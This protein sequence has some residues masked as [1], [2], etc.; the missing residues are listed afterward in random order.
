[1]NRFPLTVR[2]LEMPTFPVSS[3]TVIADVPSVALIIPVFTAAATTSFENKP[4]LHLC[5]EI[6]RLNL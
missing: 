2:L 1:M 3:A 6:A 4:S 5:V